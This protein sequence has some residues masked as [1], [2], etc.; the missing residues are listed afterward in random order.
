MQLR[1]YEAIAEAESRE[2][3]S[4]ALRDISYELDFERYSLIWWRRTAT[5][6]AHGYVH[7]AP[8]AYLSQATSPELSLADPAYQ[9]IVTTT[10][11]LVYDQSLYV[12]AGAAEL[13]DAQ[14]PFGYESGVGLA[15]EVNGG[16]ICFGFDKSGRLPKDPDRIAYLISQVTMIVAYAQDTAGLV[17]SEQQAG[18]PTLSDQRMLILRLIA[19]GKS[20]SVI[21]Q[22][23]GITPHTVNYHVRHIFA[24]L[25]VATRTQAVNEAAALLQRY[26]HQRLHGDEP[27]ALK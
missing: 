4:A 2:S 7:N 18:L 26:Q 1:F 16:R 19:E 9:H 5:K 8:D 25:G 27:L 14:A 22:L 23:M 15:M 24:A 17:L 13:W 20:N 21:A 11:P 6:R 12:R 10:R 3:L